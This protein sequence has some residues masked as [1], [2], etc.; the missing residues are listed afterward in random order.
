M[1]RNLALEDK[2]ILNNYNYIS[3]EILSEVLSLEWNVIIN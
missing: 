1:E 2:L 3:S